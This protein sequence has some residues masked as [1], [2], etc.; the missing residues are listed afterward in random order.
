MTTRR[1]PDDLER[2]DREYVAERLR[3]FWLELGTLPDF[4]LRD[5]NLLA[6]TVTT[7]LRQTVLEMMLALNGIVYP[8]G[9]R[10]LNSY[11]GPS[12][13]TAIEKTLLAQ[14][15]APPSWLG[16]AV[17]LIVIYRWYAPQLT[18]AFDLVYD[19]ALEVQTLAALQA[20]LPDWPT[21]ITTD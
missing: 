6:A 13:R 5:E 15:T 8:A 3:Q 1:W 4:L 17:S 14:V 18:D 2:P 21:A 7:R 16:Q 9:T 19:S 10:H 20:Q 11:L 12:Q